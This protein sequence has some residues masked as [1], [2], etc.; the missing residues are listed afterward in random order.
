MYARTHNLLH[1]GGYNN[2]YTDG[3]ADEF[4]HGSTGECAHGTHLVF[5]RE[6]TKIVRRTSF[7]CTIF[8]TRTHH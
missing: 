6:I 7:S 4:T 3:H 5:P 1:T 2:E 8:S